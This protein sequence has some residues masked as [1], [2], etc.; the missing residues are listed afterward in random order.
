MASNHADSTYQVFSLPQLARRKQVGRRKQLDFIL[1]DIH[2]RNMAVDPVDMLASQVGAQA[3][4]GA[5]P[6]K[7]QSEGQTINDFAVLS[8]Q[9]GEGVEDPH[10]PHAGHRP[11]SYWDPPYVKASPTDEVEDYQLA[12]R[13]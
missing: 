13:C 4:N 3:R 10:A 8:A 7:W 1:E 6:S 2:A 9:E 11:L 5:A 12:G